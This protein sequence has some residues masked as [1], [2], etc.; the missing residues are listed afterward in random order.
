MAVFHFSQN[1]V[2]VRDMLKI[3]VMMGMQAT[4]ICLRVLAGMMSNSQCLF[5][6]FIIAVHTSISVSGQ[7]DTNFGITC[8]TGLYASVLMNFPLISSILDRKNS[9]KSS[10]SF[11]S[12][13]LSGK[14]FCVVLLVNLLTRWKSSLVS[15]LQSRTFLLI[16]CFLK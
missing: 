10:A 13:L 4:S 3:H 9:A 6:M 11:L 14:G 15:F 16:D 1:S 7:K 12:V 2:V 5:F 8:C